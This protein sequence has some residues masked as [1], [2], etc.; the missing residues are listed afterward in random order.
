MEPHYSC[1]VSIQVFESTCRC[2]KVLTPE[3]DDPPVLEV[4]ETVSLDGV[5]DSSVSNCYQMIPTK[6]QTCYILSVL[7]HA[8]EIWVEIELYR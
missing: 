1:I 5:C 6:H 3:A 4:I 8:F 2:K 7:E